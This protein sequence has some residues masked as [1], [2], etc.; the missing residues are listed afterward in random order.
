MDASKEIKALNSKEMTTDRI[1]G[2]LNAEEEEI[3]KKKYLIKV[4][5]LINKIEEMIA[6]GDCAN[7]NIHSICLSYEYKSNIGHLLKYQI[8]DK[9]GTE[10]NSILSSKNYEVFKKIQLE[11]NRIVKLKLSDV[12][13]IYDEA[14]ELILKPG[15]KH[16]LIKALLSEEIQNSLAYSELQSEI[17]INESSQ[18]RMKL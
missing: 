5:S 16:E 1:I 6:D 18:K 17:T 10:L 8:K 12:G 3:S 7:N 4:L 14:I 2:I 15:I 11:F 13:L 9:E